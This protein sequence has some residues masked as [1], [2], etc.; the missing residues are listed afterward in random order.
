MI[1]FTIRPGF[2]LIAAVYTAFGG[3]LCAAFIA[4]VLLHEITHAFTAQALGGKITGV[5]LGADGISIKKEG[6]MSYPKEMLAVLAGPVANLAAGVIA[7]AF[8]GENDAAYFFAGVNVAL[9]IFNLIPASGFDGGRALKLIFSCL[10]SL[11][12]A[13]KALLC[14]SVLS[15]AAVILCGVVFYIKTGNKTFLLF[16]GVYTAWIIVYSI[17]RNSEDC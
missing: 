5:T 16:A 11:N 12:F 1:L 7:A 14:I 13:E 9:G 17:H 4:A 10:F 3:R 6:L 15:A 8:A 2:L